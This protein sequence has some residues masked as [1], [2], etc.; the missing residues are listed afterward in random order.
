MKSVVL[1]PCI[2]CCLDRKFAGA[3]PVTRQYE[4]QRLVCPG[5]DSVVRLVQKRAGPHWRRRRSEMI[6]IISRRP[7]CVVPSGAGRPQA[8]SIRT[9]QGDQSLVGPASVGP[10]SF[11]D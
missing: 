1:Q 10:A 2:L 6:S 3:E 4:I 11:Q 9:G 5:C 7:T 8:R